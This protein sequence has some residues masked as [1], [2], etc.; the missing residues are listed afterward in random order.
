ME[1][2]IEKAIKNQKELD[3]A[4]DIVFGT[5]PHHKTV[6]AIESHLLKTP[7]FHTWFQT[8]DGFK[9]FNN[10]WDAYAFLQRYLHAKRNS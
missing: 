8:H 9:L 7:S 1:K 6:H 10:Y 3:E 5:Y 4:G 2:W